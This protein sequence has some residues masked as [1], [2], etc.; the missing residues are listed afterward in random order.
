V[1]W[2]RNYFFYPDP[3]F[4]EFWIRILINLQNVP[5]PTLNIQSFTMPTILKAYHGILK[6]PQ[7]KCIFDV[8]ILKLL[9]F[10]DF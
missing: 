5:D 10:Y 2:T 9:I 1:L 6:N 4:H 8:I 7:R 3:I